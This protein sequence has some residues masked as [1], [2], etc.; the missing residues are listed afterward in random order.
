MTQWL[1]KI[2]NKKMDKVRGPNSKLVTNGPE[3]QNEN[4]HSSPDKIRRLQYKLQISC[5]QAALTSHIC[6]LICLLKMTDCYGRAQLFDLAPFFFDRNIVGEVPDYE[7][8]SE[9]QTTY[10]P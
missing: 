9:F 3:A 6:E 7:S 2:N 5:E 1:D 10:A 8:V 4:K